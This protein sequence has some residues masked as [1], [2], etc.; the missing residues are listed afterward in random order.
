MGAIKKLFS[1]IAGIN[2]GGLIGVIIGIILC[3][4]FVVDAFIELNHFFDSIIMAILIFLFGVPLLGFVGSIIGILVKLIGKSWAVVG[5][6]VAVVY[7]MVVWPILADRG[8]EMPLVFWVPPAVLLICFYLLG[9][10]ARRKHPTNKSN[11]ESWNRINAYIEKGDYDNA[12]A[13][14]T[15]LIRLNPNSV[16]GYHLRGSAYAAKGDYDKALADFTAALHPDFPMAYFSRGEVYLMTGDF[17]KAIADCNEALK[18]DPSLTDSYILR[19]RAYLE[20]GMLIKPFA[21]MKSFL[22]LTPRI[23]TRTP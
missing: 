9:Q 6:V 16:S 11:P 7:C 14:S 21:T 19:G 17:G 22:S 13:E 18:F 3:I 23:K 5:G 8:Y 2:L 1:R 4:I 15:E 20:L 10:R 12:I